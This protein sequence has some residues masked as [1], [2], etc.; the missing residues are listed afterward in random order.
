[1]MILEND[2][3]LVRIS[4]GRGARI[5]SFLDKESSKDWVWKPESEKAGAGHSLDLNASF[6]EHWAGGWEEVF[7]NDAPVD[8]D[9]YKLVDHGELWRRA[10]E[11]ES[12]SSDQHELAFNLNCETYP[13]S[14][15]KKFSLDKKEAN[16]KISY[17]L[18]SRASK[19]LPYIFKFHP[20]LSIEPGDRFHLP[21]APMEPVALGFSRIL[22]KEER[23]LYPH[24]LNEE[25]QK[26]NIDR[27]LMNDGHSREFVK[28]SELPEGHCSLI[29]HRI[30]KKLSFEFSQDHLP[31]V[32]LFQSYGGFMG[33]YVAMLEPTNAGHYDLAEAHKAGACGELKPGEKKLIELNISLKEV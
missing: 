4:P 11:Q 27:V 12:H 31:Y 19:P 15:R 6:D 16:L 28:I 17:E 23:S 26:V 32:W 29:N 5:E 25:G 20:A 1:M 14:V 18:E 3:L 13:F 2:K 24:G 10:W 7:P 8:I 22:G 33:H 30:N 9:G 21:P